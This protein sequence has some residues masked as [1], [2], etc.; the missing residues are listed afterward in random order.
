MNQEEQDKSMN[1]KKEGESTLS[2]ITKGIGNFLSGAEHYVESGASSVLNVVKDNELEKGRQNEI[3]NNDDEVK[4]ESISIFRVANKVP[5][6]NKIEGGEKYENIQY[7]DAFETLSL[8]DSFKPYD[9]KNKKEMDE[10]EEFILEFRKYKMPENQSLV[11]PNLK[12]KYYN[13]LQIKNAK[14][15]NSGNEVFV[16]SSQPADENGIKRFKEEKN[17]KQELLKKLNEEHGLDHSISPSQEEV[18]PQQ[19]GPP[20]MMQQEMMQQQMMQQQQQVPPEMM[21]QQQQQ[22]PP[23]MMQQQQQ[24]GPPEMMEQ[25]GSPPEMMHPELIA[26]QQQAE[27]AK[28]QPPSGPPAELPPSGPDAALPPPGM[29]R[30]EV[31]QPRPSGGKKN[32][33]KKGKNKRK[34]H[35]KKSKKSR[36]S[37]RRGRK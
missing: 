2:S 7:V 18:S 33:R 3:K 6:Y 1:E 28:Q 20:E 24:Q 11:Q 12:Y 13:L 37:K 29:I 25:E 35:K 4:K 22:G 23:E 5:Q 26:A 31:S 21:Q 10:E 8:T 32:T 9:I 34:T 16:F 19:Q 15:K 14:F 27:L 17:K 30:D 36:K